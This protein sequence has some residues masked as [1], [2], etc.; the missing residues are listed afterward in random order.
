M[1]WEELCRSQFV[2]DDALKIKAI[3]TVTVG[4][5]VLCMLPVKGTCMVTVLLT[6]CLCLRF[7][8]KGGD[9][10][11]MAIRGPVTFTVR[12]GITITVT[13]TVTAR[14]RSR[15]GPMGEH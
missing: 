10:I 9:V 5:E 6:L 15:L 13:I 2:Q 12:I 11:W 3:V 7:I 1:G 8:F 14:A 4:T